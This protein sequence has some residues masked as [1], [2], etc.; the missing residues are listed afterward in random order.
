MAFSVGSFSWLSA[1]SCQESTPSF[2]ISAIEAGLFGLHLQHAVVLSR[3]CSSPLYMYT[4]AISS[5]VQQMTRQRKEFSVLDLNQV[6]QRIRAMQKSQ[7]QNMCAR[8]QHL[9]TIDVIP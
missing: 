8:R 6:K 7:K 5:E 9:L 4:I 3:I 2:L 1:S